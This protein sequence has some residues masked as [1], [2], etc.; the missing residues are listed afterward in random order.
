MVGSVTKSTIKVLHKAPFRAV[1]AVNALD[2]MRIRCRRG[3][4]ASRFLWQVVK[5]GP[6]ALYSAELVETLQLLVVMANRSGLAKAA[7]ELFGLISG[8]RRPFWAQGRHKQQQKRAPKGIE[9]LG[10]WRPQGPGCGA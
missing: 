3:R 9:R 5:F 6:L 7:E 4:S 8:A 1:H 2:F 10:R